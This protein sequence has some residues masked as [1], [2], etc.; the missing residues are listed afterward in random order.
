MVVPSPMTR[1]PV[2]HFGDSCRTKKGMD[3]Y[4]EEKM[5]DQK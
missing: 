1:R 3:E 4:D 5:N 2:L